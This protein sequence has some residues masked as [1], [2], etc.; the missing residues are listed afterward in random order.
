MAY[1]PEFILGLKM[2]S[3]KNFTESFFLRWNGRSR[4]YSKKCL[5]LATA[6]WGCLEV[7]KKKLCL[8]DIHPSWLRKMECFQATDLL[9]RQ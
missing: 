1:L 5:G 6:L 3:F 4:R 7:R 2:I 8:M 9:K